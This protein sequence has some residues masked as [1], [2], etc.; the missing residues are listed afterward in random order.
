VKDADFHVVVQ[1]VR[2][3]KVDAASQQHCPGHML[4]G[5]HDDLGQRRSVRRGALG[6]STDVTH[7]SP[8]NDEAGAVPRKRT[9]HERLSCYKVPVGFDL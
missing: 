3:E 8:S 5:E 7:P 2:D 6:G 1:W 4:K 9:Q